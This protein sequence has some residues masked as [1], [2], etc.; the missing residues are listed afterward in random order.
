VSAV[1]YAGGLIG[2]QRARTVVVL[3]ITVLNSG[4]RTE[5]VLNGGLIGDWGDFMPQSITESC[6]EG[7]MEIDLDGITC[8]DH[9]GEQT[10]FALRQGYRRSICASLF[11]TSVND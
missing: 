3:G 4:D 1:T 2:T 7:E 5:V 6:S 9:K 11:A 8:V 10:P